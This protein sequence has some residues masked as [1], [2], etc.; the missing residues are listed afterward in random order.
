MYGNLRKESFGAQVEDERGRRGMYIK[1]CDCSE[2]KKDC[3]HRGSFR[4]FPQEFGG[5]GACLN[6]KTKGRGTDG[7]DKR[8]HG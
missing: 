5:T 7:R 4:R 3:P 6:L 1:E 8:H 2:C